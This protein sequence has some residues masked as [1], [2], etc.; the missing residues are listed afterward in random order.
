[1]TCSGTPPASDELVKMAD[2]LMYAVKSVSKNG[3]K[4]DTYAGKSY[5]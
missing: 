2:Q 4:Y 3:V 1:L 5:V